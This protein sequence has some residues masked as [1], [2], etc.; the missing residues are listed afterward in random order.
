VSSMG[1]IQDFLAQRRIAVVGISH[2]PNDFSRG[3]LRTLRLRGYE[4]L[5]V[6]PSLSEA[7]GEPCYSRLADVA[8]VDGVLLMTS[9][10]ITDQVVQECAALRIPRVWMY[11]AG[12]KGGAV[13]PQAVEY[14]NDHGIKVVPG[15]CPFMFL[16]DESWFHRL[17]GF[18]RR[19]TGL[20][21]S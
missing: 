16:S 18:V 8:P 12:R 4:A 20:Y 7:D 17:H 19:I 21:P 13:S 1:V 11:R 14:C 10:K 6:N 9:P 5:A 2:D 3:L 15:E